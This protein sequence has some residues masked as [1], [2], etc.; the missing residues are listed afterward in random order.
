MNISVKN[1]A[2]VVDT[3]AVVED[4]RMNHPDSRLRSE[5]GYAAEKLKPK[6]QLAKPD[7]AVV[8]IAKHVK[9]NAS[10][11][12]LIAHEKPLYE[13]TNL[14]IPD[15]ADLKTMLETMGLKHLIKKK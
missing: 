8:E 9:D 15:D 13:C 14:V 1:P 2:F 12:D 11:M 7:A 4:L 5:A 6:E 10:D 3:Y